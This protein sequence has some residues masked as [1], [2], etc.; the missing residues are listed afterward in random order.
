VTALGGRYVSVVTRDG[1]EHLI[2]NETLIS[3]RVENWTHT[4]N[5]TRL[6]IDFGVH[7][8]SD[9]RE[10]ISVAL[11]AATETPRVLDDPAPKCLLIEFGD[12]SVNFQL[13]VW[14]A[15]AQNGVQNVKSA[16]ML[17]VWDKFQEHGIEI[18]YPQRDVYLHRPDSSSADI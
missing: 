16:V 13:R 11:E 8:R 15:D 6:K 4:N 12:S 10:V 3:E 9:V 5:R 17:A 7:Y 1:V 2:P 14:I 18:P